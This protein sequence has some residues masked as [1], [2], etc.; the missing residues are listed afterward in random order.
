M[1]VFAIVIAAT[2]IYFGAHE[3][4]L[5]QATTPNSP[6]P[7]FQG[8]QPLQTSLLLS[9][10]FRLRSPR[11]YELHDVVQLAGGK[12]PDRLLHPGADRVQGRDLKRDSEY[13][14]RNGLQFEPARVSDGLLSAILTNWKITRAAV[15]CYCASAPLPSALVGRD[16]DTKLAD[17][18]HRPANRHP[19]GGRPDDHLEPRSRRQIASGDK[20]LGGPEGV[21]RRRSA[22][23]G[24][25]A[26]AW[27]LTHIARKPAAPP[28][29]PPPPRG[30]R[31][32][33]RGYIRND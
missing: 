3:V 16:P 7:P 12:L 30:R 20:L 9:K 15:C 23:I 10:G 29:P 32:N 24:L 13:G 1:W 25:A 2:S 28:G 4:A 22:G 8:F 19:E 6:L 21:S 14:L 18:R 33:R 17:L 11:R 31:Q 26:R 27:V 5:A